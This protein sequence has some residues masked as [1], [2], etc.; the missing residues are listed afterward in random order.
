MI[1]VMD[2]E[3][4]SFKCFS[5]GFC[6]LCGPAFDSNPALPSNTWDH[7]GAAANATPRL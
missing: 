3:V 2:L 6:G 7:D 4:C 5:S 1:C